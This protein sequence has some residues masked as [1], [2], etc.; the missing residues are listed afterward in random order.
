[1]HVVK[2]RLALFLPRG[3]PFFGAQSIDL[4][5][6]LKQR[7][8]PLDGLKRDR[9]D[10]LAFTFAVAGIFLDVSQ[11]KEFAPRVR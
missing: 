7:L 11:F 6:D 10:R 1:M 5:F 3:Q 8:V 4:A 9:R 2:Q